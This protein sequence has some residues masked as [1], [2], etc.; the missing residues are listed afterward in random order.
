MAK[1]VTTP[2]SP[3]YKSSRPKEFAV[4]PVRVSAEDM[5]RLESNSFTY[6]TAVTEAAQD[7]ADAVERCDIG[8]ATRSALRLGDRLAVLSEKADNLQKKRKSSRDAQTL[9]NLGTM[10]VDYYNF[11]YEM[12]KQANAGCACNRK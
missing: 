10:I 7:L 12:E 8:D 4:P 11:C 9:D 1:K 2:S 6:L 5:N 3:P